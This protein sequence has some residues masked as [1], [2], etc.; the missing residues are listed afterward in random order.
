MY[1]NV[2]DMHCHSDNS[3]DGHHSMIFI[4]E[5]AKKIGARGLAFTDHC[6]IDGKDFD[7]RA[8][9]TNTFV[10][11]QRA[12][13]VF[14]GDLVVMNGLEIGQAIYNKARAE[15]IINAL[16][17]DFILASIH[18]LE[19]ME[20]FYFL[21]YSKYDV[22]DLLKKYF[23]TV[24]ELAKWNNF[25]SLAHLTYPLR[26][27]VGESKIDVDLDKY[28]DTIDEILETIINNGKALEINTSGLFM[29][30]E[31]TLPTFDIIKKFHDMGGQYITI[32]SDSHYA[33]KICQGIDQ[34]MKLAKDAGFDNITIYHNREHIL[35]PIE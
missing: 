16:Q 13:N 1:K 11:C 21:D 12:K 24:L 20:D 5:E 15:K 29:K 23:N 25:D 2:I 27:I 9:T 28:S 35:V 26:Y 34:G 19:N 22:D 10:E 14:A 33:N 3:F 18:N 8:F 31:E 7:F 32:G 30:L 17:Y 6:E 4:C